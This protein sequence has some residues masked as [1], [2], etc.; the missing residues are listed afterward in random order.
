MDWDHPKTSYGGVCSFL[1]AC[2][3]LLEILQPVAL[4]HAVLSEE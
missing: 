1:R 3:L 2:G 4:R